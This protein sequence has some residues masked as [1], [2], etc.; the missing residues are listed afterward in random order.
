MLQLTLLCVV[1]TALCLPGIVLGG[2]GPIDPCSPSPCDPDATCTPTCGDSCDPNEFTCT[3][4]DGFSGDGNTCADIDEC[5]AEDYGPVCCKGF[6]CTNT[7]G[8]F[9]CDPRACKRNPDLCENGFCIDT[10]DDSFRCKCRLGFK[11]DEDEQ[12]CVENNSCESDSSLCE[13]G[14]CLNIGDSFRCLCGFGY[15]PAPDGQ[16]CVR[17]GRRRFG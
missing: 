7:P 3:C 6:D 14:W 10:E 15:K 1:L 17:Q 11:P 5:E 9:T 13:N 2:N 16:S 4:N 8:S 12:S